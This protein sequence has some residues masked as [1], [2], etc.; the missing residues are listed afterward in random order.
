MRKIG[1]LSDNHS[2]YG[3]EIYQ[4]LLDVDEIWHSGDIGNIKSI[5]KIKEI[6]VFRAVYG[7]IDDISVKEYYPLNNIFFCEGVK[8]L[9]T[10]IGGYP[11]R[12]SPRVKDLLRIERPDLYICGHSHICKVVK[13]KEFN[14][15]HMNP[16][17]YGHYG[18]HKI[19]TLLKFEID[20]RKIVNLRVVELGLRGQIK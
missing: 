14:I 20:E 8:V 15:L 1:L 13:D 18:F 2:Y 16:G 3:E 17:S 6:G 4:N 10:H 7:N 5:E 9:M 19:R 12:Y 11:G